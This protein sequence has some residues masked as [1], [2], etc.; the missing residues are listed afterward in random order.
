MSNTLKT[1]VLQNK[2]KKIRVN[3]DTLEKNIKSLK[4]SLEEH[5]TIEGNIVEKDAILKTLED[6]KSSK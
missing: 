3:I 1:I 5:F 6:I 4:K 2:L